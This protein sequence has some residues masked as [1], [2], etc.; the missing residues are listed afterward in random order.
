MQKKAQPIWGWLGIKR[1][2]KVW[3]KH[4]RNVLKN[5]ELDWIITISLL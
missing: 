5:G 1:M 3:E 4:P 2:F